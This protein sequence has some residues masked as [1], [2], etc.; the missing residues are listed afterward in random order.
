MLAFSNT[1][2]AGK[3]ENTIS[4]LPGEAGVKIPLSLCWHLRVSW[5]Q[6]A[7]LAPYVVSI[8]TA[9]GWP[10]YWWEMV[11]VLTLLSLLWC[12]PQKGGGRAPHYCGLGWKSR[13]PFLVSADTT[14]QRRRCLL[15][16]GGD[17]SP[18]YLLGLLWPYPARGVGVPP[19]FLIRVEV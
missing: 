3:M 1:A 13:L 14:G 15:L 7:V 10:H 17:K 8:V 4:L 6:V 12:H 11:K 18:S 19:Y 16:P 9:L 5:V 2:V